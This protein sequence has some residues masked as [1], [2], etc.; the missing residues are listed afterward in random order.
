VRDSGSGCRDVNRDTQ[1]DPQR[2]DKLS[3]VPPTCGCEQYRTSQYSPGVITDNEKL[4]R[5]VFA[6]V[7][8][9]KNGGVKP[10]LFNQVHTSGCSVQRDSIADNSEITS[11]VSTFLGA[12]EDRVWMGVV[13]AECHNIRSIRIDDRS[14]R[15]VCVFDTSGKNNPAHGEVC[16]ARVIDEADR[17]ELRNH[18]YKA[19]NSK[20]VIT[21]ENYRAG[22]VWANL[23]KELRSRPR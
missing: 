12:G 21:P 5:F 9:S 20:A 22:D 23:T 4:T 1:D 18:L 3:S 8:V 17:V 13:S 6:P 14:E 15:A 19:F 10:S 2:A 7:H 16:R 11:F